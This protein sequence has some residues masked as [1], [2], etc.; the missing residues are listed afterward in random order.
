VS[1]IAGSEEKSQVLLNTNQRKLWGILI[2]ELVRW[3]QRKRRHAKEV[4]K[5]VEDTIGVEIHKR[6]EY[7]MANFELAVVAMEPRP[8]IKTGLL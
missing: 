7:S 1:G 2:V 8:F 6:V 4:D 3:T 5:R